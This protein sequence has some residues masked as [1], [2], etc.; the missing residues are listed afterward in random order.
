[1][2]ASLAERQYVAGLAVKARR[3]TH[4]VFATRLLS[5]VLTFASIM[6]RSASCCV[7]SDCS[8]VRR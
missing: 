1:M 8:I 5:V 6:I 2:S 7:R 3:G 4:A